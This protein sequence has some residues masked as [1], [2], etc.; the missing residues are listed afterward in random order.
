MMTVS[1]AAEACG[2]T[3]HTLRYYER[4]GLLTGVPRSGAGRR[5]YGERELKSVRFIARLRAT[6]MPVLEIKRYADLVRAGEHTEGQRLDVLLDHRAAVENAL[7]VQ[8]EHLTAIETK[9][10]MYQ[11]HLSAGRVDDADKG[12]R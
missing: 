12:D 10:A 1:Q 2:I 7:N 11:E 5:R 6:G 8:R 4:A 3:A 9:I